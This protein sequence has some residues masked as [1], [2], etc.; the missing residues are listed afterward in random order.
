VSAADVVADA[1]RTNLPSGRL[2]VAVS[3]GA[4]SAVAAWGCIEV[5]GNRRVRLVHVDH[6]LPDSPTMR[7][8]ANLVADALGMRL[9]VVAVNLSGDGSE[10]TRARIA[11]LAA[12][13]DTADRDEWIVTGHHRDDDAE[14]VLGNLLRGAGAGGLS[15]IAS[16]RGRY[17]R[18]LLGLS[19]ETIRE[20]ADTLRL[21]YRNDPANEDLR[22]RRT[23]IRHRLLP[24]L[25]AGFGVD[26]RGALHRSAGLISADDAVLEEAASA[27]PITIDGA[28][29]LLPAP[30][31]TTLPRPIAS[32]AIRRAMRAVRPPYPGSAAE[33]AAVMDV[34]TDGGRRQLL[35][36]WHAVREGVAVAIVPELQLPDVEPATLPIPGAVRFGHGHVLTATVAPC[37]VGLRRADVA[38]FAAEVVGTSVAVRSP[39][40]GDRID[41]GSGSKSVR[42]A[43][44]EGDIPLRHRSSWP[45]VVVRG[46]IAWVPGVRVAPWARPGHTAAGTVLIR[47]E[48]TLA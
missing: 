29:A 12:L 23:V 27:V 14:T 48:R 4:D 20:A 45:V 18:P 47:W 19:K 11:R 2:M 16:R 31:L 35:A 22:H 46:T 37:P 3:G 34:A 6:G 38:P 43:L 21:P 44:A 8:A 28:A 32:R 42:D 10:E 30:L 1:V 17:V 25:E 9:H 24:E 40:V 15:G 5:A 7:A 39:L 33:V 36:G 41:I 13:E 26:V